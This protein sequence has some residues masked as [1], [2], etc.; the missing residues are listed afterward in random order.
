M[1]R[2]GS[3]SMSA[4]F[5]EPVHGTAR[6]S[7][8]LA[9]GVVVRFMPP[10]LFA[11]RQRRFLRLCSIHIT[12]DLR[13]H[14]LAKPLATIL[15]TQRA[16]KRRICRSCLHSGLFGLC[17]SFVFVPGTKTKLRAFGDQKVFCVVPCFVPTDHAKIR[18]VIRRYDGQNRRPNWS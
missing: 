16:L 5:R 4:G 1:G 10:N 2:D 17:R 7:S 12:S 9:N 6:E 8:P 3:C 11:S 13:K 14:E 18:S 15:F